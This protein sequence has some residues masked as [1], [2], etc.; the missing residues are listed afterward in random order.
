MMKAR[1][2]HLAFRSPFFVLSG[3]LGYYVASD[4]TTRALVLSTHLARIEKED[5]YS[6]TPLFGRK[7]CLHLIIRFC[8]L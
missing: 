6:I 8:Q 3:S 5:I 2:P 7:Q 4:A 1:P